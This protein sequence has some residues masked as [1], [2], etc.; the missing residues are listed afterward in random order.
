[1]MRLRVPAVFVVLACIIA[2]SPRPAAAAVE[3]KLNYWPVT[4]FNMQTHFEGP[5]LTLARPVLW[6]GDLRWTSQRQWGIH[7]KYDTGTDSGWSFWFPANATTTHTMWSGDVFYALQVSSATFRGFVGYGSIQWTQVAPAPAQ[8]QLTASGW[9]FGADAMFPLPDSNW[10]INMSAAFYPSSSTT[11][12]YTGLPS[13]TGTS[14]AGD[15]SASIQYTWP[16]GWL[17][18]AGYRLVTLNTGSLGPTYTA[19]WTQQWSGPFFAAGY[20]W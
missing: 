5:G 8:Q 20:H 3:L 19:P 18:E 12:T 13:G 4:Q 16:A 11:F 14:S 1:M 10:A 2:L 6:G 17:A 15:Y 9:R 7:L